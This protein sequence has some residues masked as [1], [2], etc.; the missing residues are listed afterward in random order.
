M[1]ASTLASEGNRDHVS[2]IYTDKTSQNEASW[3]FTVS[4]SKDDR[5]EGTNRVGVL[6][7]YTVGK[8]LNW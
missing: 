1:S 4:T 5:F 8:T 6:S 3:N 7:M 2:L